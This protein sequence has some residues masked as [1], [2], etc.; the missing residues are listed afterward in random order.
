MRLTVLVPDLLWPEPGDQDTLANLPCPGLA[1]LLARGQ[2]QQAPRRDTESALAGCFGL[3]D[4]APLAALRLL[5]EPLTAFGPNAREGYWLCADP[6]HLRFHHERIVLADAGAFDLSDDE[7]HTLAIALN[8]TFA[9]IG[10]FHVTTA[11]R[12]YLRLHTAIDHEAAPLS[13]VAG[14]RMDG[15]LPADG[16]PSPLRRWLNEI[17]MFLHG[18]PVNEARQAAGQ[19]AINSLWLWGGGTLADGQPPAFTSVWSS[20]PL[21]TGLAR[22]GRIPTQGLPDKLATLL[23]APEAGARPLVVLD[24]LQGPVLYEDGD[25]WRSALQNLEAAWFAPLRQALGGRITGIQL[26]APTI[27]GQLTWTIGAGDRWKL[28]RRPQ[29]IAALATHFATT[30]AP[31]AP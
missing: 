22:A 24:S 28:W 4:K 15:D 31:T 25:G 2:V 12:W 18:H 19:P 9:D 1:W 29:P 23:A 3:A 26:V 6:V 27:Y 21:A 13:A 11:R 20:S 16:Q 8:Q 17:Q 10:E 7:A 30:S 14:R 5:G